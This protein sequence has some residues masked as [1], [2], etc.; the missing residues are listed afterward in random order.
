MRV[1]V[2]VYACV[3]ARG[4]SL[5]VGNANTSGLNPFVE[6]VIKAIV[7]HEK[8]LYQSRQQKRRREK[9]GVCG[10]NA[11]HFRMHRRGW[12]THAHARTQWHVRTMVMPS[13]LISLI[14]ARA[15]QAGALLSIKYSTF[16]QQKQEAVGA[17]VRHQGRRSG[18]TISF[19]LFLLLFGGGG[20][21]C[22]RHCLAVA[23]SV[24]G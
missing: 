9:W 14:V 4:N 22:D 20:G 11:A 8:Q 17:G 23:A 10:T 6:A 16:A 2:R 24:R 18:K 7:C 19:L 1:S 5:I 13:P 21:W 3:C 15:Q 12:D